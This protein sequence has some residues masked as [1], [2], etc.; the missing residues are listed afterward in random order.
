MT[1]MLK[2][3]RKAPDAASYWLWIAWG[4]VIGVAGMFVDEAVHGF[5]PRLAIMIVI[6]VV[7]TATLG[8]VGHWRDERK[9]PVS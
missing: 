8:L 1:L 5:W 3:K 4:L 7:A 6:V 2:M 9:Q